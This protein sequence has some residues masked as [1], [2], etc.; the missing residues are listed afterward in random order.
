[1]ILIRCRLG[2]FL[3]LRN[4]YIVVVLCRA[5]A[6]LSLY[7][8]SIY[9]VYDGISLKYHD[10]VTLNNAIIWETASRQSIELIELQ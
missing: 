1:M 4:L 7:F 9:Y 10:A 6:M 3:H 8:L 2:A 5:A